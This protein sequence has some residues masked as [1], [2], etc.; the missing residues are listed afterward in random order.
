[1]LSMPHDIHQKARHLPDGESRLTFYLCSGNSM[2]GD[3]GAARYWR[4]C[5]RRS[6]RA[7]PGL[8]SMGGSAPENDIVAMGE[9][10]LQRPLIVDATDM[11]L[12]PGEIRIIDPG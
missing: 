11:G 4:K 12:N 6:R 8:S 1:M 3:D 7:Q 2:M 5:A 10:R 9:P